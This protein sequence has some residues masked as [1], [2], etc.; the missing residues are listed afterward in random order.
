LVPLG[1]HV[2]AFEVDGYK[3]RD[4]LV[5]VSRSLPGKQISRFTMRDNKTLFLFVFRNELMKQEAPT[6]VEETKRVIEDVFGDAEWEWPEIKAAMKDVEDIY[7]DQVSQTRMA[8]WTKGRT[9]LIGDAAACI[10]LLG[11]EGTGLAMAEAYVLAGELDNASGDH[12]TAFAR[13][14]ARLRPFLKQKQAT[15]AKLASSF[16]PQT[17]IGIAIRDFIVN[18]LRIPIVANYFIGRDLRDDIQLPD[19]N[20][21]N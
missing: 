10:S 11:G 12:A 18:L 7:F 14:E 17:G 2:A 13:F 9:A 19:Y 4:E 21:E 20:F 1:F 3:H 5:Y 16:A 15:A 6:T 8:S